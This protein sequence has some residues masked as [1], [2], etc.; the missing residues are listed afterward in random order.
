MRVQLQ[1]QRL[2]HAAHLWQQHKQHTKHTVPQLPL[3][4]GTA[5]RLSGCWRSH[6]HSCQVLAVRQHACSNAL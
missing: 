1:H 2:L 5:S 3:A 6:R 4:G